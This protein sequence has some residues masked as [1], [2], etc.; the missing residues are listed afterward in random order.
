MTGF[1]GNLKHVPSFGHEGPVPPC[2]QEHAGLNS[3]GEPTLCLLPQP[4]SRGATSGPTPAV[5]PLP[6]LFTEGLL[7]AVSATL[8]SPSRRGHC[9]AANTPPMRG[10]SL[11]M[12]TRFGPWCGGARLV[13]PGKGGRAPVTHWAA[14][15]HPGQPL[16]LLPHQMALVSLLASC[17][18]P[19]LAWRGPVAQP[20]ISEEILG[21]GAVP[22]AVNT[23]GGPFRPNLW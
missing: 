16:F 22:G 3:Q 10:G 5:W 12:G 20:V 18:P 15:G 23:L 2:A 19:Q 8:L 13:L 4:H 17:F 1:P 9:P 6:S 11:L 21:W 7:L 14:G